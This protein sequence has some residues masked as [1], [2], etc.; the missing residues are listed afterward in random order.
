[1]TCPHDPCRKLYRKKYSLGQRKA[2]Q[3]FAKPLMLNQLDACADEPAR[4][5]LLGV[6][7]RQRTANSSQRT[8]KSGQ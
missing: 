6:S 4:R 2:D 8:V 5:L 3:L 7:K 1:M